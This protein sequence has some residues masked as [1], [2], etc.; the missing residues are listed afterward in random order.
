[1]FGIGGGMRGGETCDETGVFGGDGLFE[2]FCDVR[3]NC[4]GFTEC[5]SRDVQ[6]SDF[7]ECLFDGGIIRKLHDRLVNKNNGEKI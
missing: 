3:M 6:G 2:L 7:V 1:M 4:R 5:F